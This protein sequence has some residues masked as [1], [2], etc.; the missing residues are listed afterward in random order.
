MVSPTD[1]ELLEAIAGKDEAALAVFLNRHL[2]SVY[3]FVLRFTSDEF[4]AEDV[5]QEV[6]LRVYQRAREY[7]AGYAV[8]SWLFAIARNT[9][10]DAVRARKSWRQA[11]SGFH[12][13]S[14]ASDAITPELEHTGP[15][16]EEQLSMAQESRKVLDALQTLPENQRTA[17]ILQY[18][19]GLAVKE[20]AGVL[21]T[22]ASAVE[23]LLIRAKRN[24]SKF[25][26]A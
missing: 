26:S 23:S 21:A 16:P 24:L 2:V 15:S 18:Y 14:S 1:K 20:I 5:S 10:I 6:F 22:S 25:L 7:D 9:A 17:I 11:V 4:L 19:E 13:F 3:K 8:K 12:L